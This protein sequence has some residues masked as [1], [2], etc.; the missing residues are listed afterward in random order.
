MPELPDVEVFRRYTEQNAVGRDL[1]SAEVLDE[2]C[3]DGVSASEFEQAVSATTFAGTRRIGKQLFVSLSSGR[4][5]TLHFGMTGYPEF[6][7]E[8]RPA[9]YAR[10]V[11]HFADGAALSYVLKRMLGRIGLAESPERFAAERGLGE[12]AL[13]MSEERFSDLLRTARGGAKS[14]LMNQSRI[15]GIGNMYSDEILFDAGVHPSSACRALDRSALS[16]LDHARRSIFET[17]IERHVDPAAMPE[18]WLFPRREDGTSCPRCGGRIR[19]EVIAGRGAYF[20]AD[21][22][23]LYRS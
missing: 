16:R 22:Q 9:D 2:R 1:F 6:S 18:D 5:L 23:H 15:A 8:G 10:V 17:A 11:F 4:W 20:C 13:R 21:H 3:L 14:L 12:D 7:P 19:R